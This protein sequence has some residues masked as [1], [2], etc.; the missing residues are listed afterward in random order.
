MLTL[1]RNIPT[2]LE[3]VQTAWGFLLQPGNHNSAAVCWQHQSQASATLQRVT[4]SQIL[5][6]KWL[7][8][9]QQ[10]QTECRK[11]PLS[12]FL[13]SPVQ[14]VTKVWLSYLTLLFMVT[15]PPPAWPHYRLHTRFR[16]GEEQLERGNIEITWM[17]HYLKL[18]IRVFVF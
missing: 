8:A 12:A 13:L 14:R 16:S 6:G 2:Q 3:C 4:E 1:N 5:F 15:V 17:L 9:C 7:E 10:R 11:M 18:I